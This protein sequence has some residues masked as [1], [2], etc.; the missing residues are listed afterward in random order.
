[1]LRLLLNL[2]VPEFIG[3]QMRGLHVQLCG[4]YQLAL[5]G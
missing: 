1:M 5:F 4:G 3:F 2:P